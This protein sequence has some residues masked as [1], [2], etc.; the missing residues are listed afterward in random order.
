MTV[1]APS[2]SLR[3][4]WTSAASIE[5]AGARV[6]P[7][8]RLALYLYI[9]SIPF[10][11]PQRTIP[12]EIPTLMGA[13]FLLTTVLQPSACFRRV[14]AAF[15]WFLVYLWAFGMVV[16]INQVTQSALVL[17]LFIWMLEVILIFWVCTNLLADDRIMRG[18]LLTLIAACTVRA[19]LQ[20][21]GVGVMAHEVV[22]GSRVTMF[23]QNTNLTSMILGAGMA[24]AVGLQLSPGRE[25]PRLRLWTWPVAALIGLA[26]IQTGSRGGLLGAALGMAAFALR[27]RSLGERIRNGVF[28]TGVLAL[29]AWGA[30]QTDV[31]RNRF[32]DAAITGHLAGREDIYPALIEMVRERPVFGWGPIAN[33]FEI[34][35]RIDS[36]DLP[37][38]DAHN[39]VGELLTTGG[40]FITIPFLMGMG[41]C[42]RAAWRA[43]HGPLEWTALAILVTVLTGTIS[44][45]WIAAKI[46]WLALAIALAAGRS[47]TDPEWREAHVPIIRRSQSCAA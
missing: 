16:V 3:Q 28:A 45:T 5:R 7:I 17:Q 41:L 6:N 30:F 26:I 37:R 13:L 33:Q 46:V 31:M 44:G 25:L 4:P 34:A 38:R 14:P 39:L 15:V 32:E 29:L 9:F 18:L 42:I 24:A 2:V 36:R 40:V 12:V 22:G 23:G 8:I 19:L 21:S 20:V 1:P 43:R 11:M 10:E 27:G 35:N 47:V